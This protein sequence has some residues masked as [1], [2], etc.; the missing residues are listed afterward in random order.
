MVLEPNAAI[1]DSVVSKEVGKRWDIS[2]EASGGFEE[3]CGGIMEGGREVRAPETV[4]EGE[5]LGSVGVL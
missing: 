2:G 4:R 1:I 5:I 3:V